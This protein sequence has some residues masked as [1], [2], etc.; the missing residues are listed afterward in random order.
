MSMWNEALRRAELVAAGAALARRGLVR[1]REGN[2]SCRLDQTHLLLTPR[3]VDKGRL[4]AT[5]LVLVDL[6]GPLPEQASSEA[7]VHIAVYR[8]CQAVQALVHA[9]PLRV[10][11]LAALGATPSPA[12]LEEGRAL[13]P[14]IELV[15][16]AQPGSAELA[17]G[18]ARAMQRAPAAVLAGHGVL[19]GG[20]D[21]WQALERVEVVELLAAVALA[22]AERVVAI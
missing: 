2:L 21:I 9:H 13:V 1:G 16:Q 20:T 18:C 12:R 3:G 10:L 14:M 15:A 4:A 17:A 22:A 19:C 7:Q 6:H 11:A 5:D 8:A